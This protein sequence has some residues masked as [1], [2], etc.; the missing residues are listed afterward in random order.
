VH[1]ALDRTQ[2]LSEPIRELRLRVPAEVG[3]LDRLAL[4]VGELRQ[5]ARDALALEPQPDR[6]VGLPRRRIGTIGLLGERLGPA[7]LVRASG[8]TPWPTIAPR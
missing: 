4:L 1:P 8:S 2:R 5:R 6:F 3:E 7:P